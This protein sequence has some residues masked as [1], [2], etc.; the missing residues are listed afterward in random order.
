MRRVRISLVVIAAAF[1]ACA[2]SPQRLSASI[3]AHEQRA[4]A[5]DAAGDRGA[6]R[7]EWATAQRQRQAAARQQA[8]QFR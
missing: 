7:A 3:Y 8:V 1:A 6:A 2:S 5:F 4:G